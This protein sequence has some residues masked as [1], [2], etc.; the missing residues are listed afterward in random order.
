M[1]DKYE[2]NEKDIDSTLNFL[3]YFDPKNET[4][5]KAIAFLE[6]MYVSSHMMLH[7]DQK[8]LENLYKE[9]LEQDI[10]VKKHNI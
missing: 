8:A 1:S 4:P 3:H 10:N 9:F 7:T 2:L 6:Y 5:E